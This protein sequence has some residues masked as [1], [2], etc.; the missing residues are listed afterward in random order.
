MRSQ[1]HRL[2]GYIYILNNM[3]FTCAVRTREA[4][5]TWTLIRSYTC[6]TIRTWRWAGTNCCKIII[7][8]RSSSMCL[9]FRDICTNKRGI[10]HLPLSRS[11]DRS[12]F[13]LHCKLRINRHTDECSGNFR[14]VAGTNNIVSVV[15]DICAYL[16]PILRFIL[17]MIISFTHRVFYVFVVFDKH[18]KGQY[19]HQFV[20]SSR[21][22]ADP[23]QP[24]LVIRVR[25]HRQVFYKR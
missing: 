12:K 15:F 19:F 24:F 23:S 8:S 3:C 1:R 25:S 22:C 13:P 6:T 20:T 2:R 18:N 21:L 5:S 16:R 14:F 17:A 7:H 10:Q 9:H 11:T 4:R